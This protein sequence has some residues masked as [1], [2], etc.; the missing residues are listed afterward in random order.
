MWRKHDS[1]TKGA[2]GYSPWWG[3]TEAWPTQAS[4]RATEYLRRRL[5]WEFFDET[6]AAIVKFQFIKTETFWGNNLVSLRSLPSG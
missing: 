5:G 1:D 3:P 6:A 4:E 2:L